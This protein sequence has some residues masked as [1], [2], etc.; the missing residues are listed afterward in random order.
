M[1]EIKLRGLWTIAAGA[2]A[3]A[4]LASPGLGDTAG[5]SAAFAKARAA[6][7]RGDG[8]AAEV[9]LKDAQAQG[10]DVR[11]VAAGMGEAF[12]VEG[13]LDKA[14]D[15][16]GPGE[17]ADADRTRGLRMLS[18]LESQQGN[19]AAALAALE[20]AIDSDAKDAD[21]WVDLAQLRY[22]TGNQL[23]A[24]DSLQSALEAG[25]DNLRALDFQG[26][27]VR[28]QFG[29]EAALDW[30]ERG[31]LKS[32]NDGVL[33][34]DYAATLGELG[35]Y[36]QMLVITRR[37]LELGVA[38]PR[39]HYLQAVLAARVGNLSL[40]RSCLNRAGKAVD[41]MPAARLLSGAIHLQE[42][43]PKLA[44]DAF[45]RL[46]QQQPQ[47]EAAQL[48]LARAL[49]EAGDQKGV[50]ARFSGWASS[51]SAPTYLLT[52][53]AR[54]YED[55][56]ERGLAAPLLDRAAA[57]QQAGLR[58]A[59][60]FAASGSGPADMAAAQVRSALG[61]GRA[62]EAV[63]IAER[64]R[65]D[66]HGMG[67]AHLLAGD[68]YFA[69][70]RFDMATNAYADAARVRADDTL[71][72]RLVLANA[73]QG[74]VAVAAQAASHYLIEH[75]QSPVA[76]RLAA[77]YAASLGD[78]GRARL[79]LEHLTAGSGSRDMRLLSDLSFAQMRLGD[80]KAAVRSARR[81]L[82]LQPA[83]PVAAQALSMAL[84]AGKQD[85]ALATALSARATRP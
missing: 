74:H 4:L 32:P 25:P 16:L 30:F 46:T 15:W 7:A 59:F 11:T 53:V 51:P 45:Q 80:T 47:N 42:G 10:A 19:T 12:L 69:A 58:P 81:A 31:L 76:A 50:I 82:E 18:R 79:L 57:V 23:A 8:V 20:R 24:F 72:A 68:A 70:G 13:K 41:D 40:A 14:R 63:A 22:R 37:M 75:P 36:R 78:W 64:L 62:G 73:Q 33:L 21:A 85:E 52:L 3:L 43:N 29:P 35:R 1:A 56:G 44:V 77:D 17:F 55:I 26:L 2:L 84:K 39:A 28:D 60:A 49:Y 67:S 27:I 71:A 83:S 66:W 9:A 48:L 61:T 38:E 54:A 65:S 6:L 5:R 34:S